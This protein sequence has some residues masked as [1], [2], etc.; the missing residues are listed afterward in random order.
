M[1]IIILL[2]VLFIWGITHSVLASHFAKD[3]IRGSLGPDLGRFYRLAYNLF[4]AV[5]FVPV[6]YLM[7][8]LPDQPVYQIPAPWNILVFGGKLI[9]AILL[10][11]T[12]LQTDSLSFMGLRQLFQKETTGQLVTH[13]FYRL[14][15]HP[16]YTFSLLFI[17][18][19]PTMTQNSLAVYFGATIYFIVGAYFEE[20]KL[21]HEFGESYA[22]YKRRTPMLIPGL[23]IPRK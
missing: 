10:F 22:E 3:M 9:A 1:S 8:N 18:L 14:M 19:T 23:I 11:I 12:F 13:G 16:L 5:S 21:L 2:L 6:L 17:W 15:R 7:N 20:R 4:S